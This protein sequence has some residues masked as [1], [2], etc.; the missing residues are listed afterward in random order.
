MKPLA[1]QILALLRLSALD[2]YRRKDLAVVFVLGGVILTPL[3]FFTPFGVSSASRYTNELAMLL[4]W[5]FSAVIGLGVSS[6]LF[7]PEF[8]SRTIYPLLSK[9]ISRGTVLVGKYLGAL[10]ASLSALAV[11]YAA[12]G[13]LAGVRQGVWFPPVLWQALLL[14]TGFMVVVTAL[15]LLGSL[16]LTASANL[17]L[18][19]LVTAGMLVFGQ[20]LPS[21]A[22][23]QPAPGRWAL[24]AIHWIA[25]HLE[26]FD[27]RQRLVHEWPPVGWGVCGAVWLYALCYAAACLALAAVIFRRKKF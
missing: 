5:L 20:R 17:T 1:R 8:E 18:C 16:V 26:F 2:L 22:A 13:V 4:V 19:A 9:P 11:F 24:Y 10:A 15:G 21:M 23:G 25:P 6:R 27:L 7:P 14:H 12:Y 3:F